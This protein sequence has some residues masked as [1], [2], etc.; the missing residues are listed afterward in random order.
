MSGR[1]R[2]FREECSERYL[3]DDVVLEVGLEEGWWWEVE[4]EEQEG[5]SKSFNVWRAKKKGGWIFV[6]V[7][8][9]GAGKGWENS[10]VKKVRW[11]S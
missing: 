7:R 10:W 3:R 11:L 6:L 4:G 5:S 2:V 1:T 8:E 9:I